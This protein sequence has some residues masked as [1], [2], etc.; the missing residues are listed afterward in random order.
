VIPETGTTKLHLL[1]GNYEV[2]IDAK[3]RML[4]PSE[5]RKAIDPIND[6][7]A[8]FLVPRADGRIWLYPDR[9]YR[10]LAQQRVRE[11]AP[12]ED[13]Q[14]FNRVHF[15]LVSRVE[16][17]NQGR[18]LLPEKEIRRAALNREVTLIGADDHI[19]IWSRAAWAAEEPELLRQQKDIDE[20][21][22][23][24]KSEGAIGQK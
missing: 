13:L 20:R 21:M 24:N 17:D 11:I 14:R 12:G 1:Y 6:G 4:I 19:E 5:I 16:W 7:E 23:Q 2:V 9:Y 10:T 22:S 3:N 8:F 15:G 18:V